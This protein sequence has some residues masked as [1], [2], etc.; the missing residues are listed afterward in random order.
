VT[1]LITLAHHFALV[2]NP[3]DAAGLASRSKTADRGDLDNSCSTDPV[4]DANDSAVDDR[5]PAIG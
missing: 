4:A 2:L 1:H 3:S 5:E